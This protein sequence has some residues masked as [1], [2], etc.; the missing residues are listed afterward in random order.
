[1]PVTDWGEIL[2]QIVDAFDGHRGKI[3]GV[4]AG[5]ILSLLII[6][7]GLIRSLFI[8]FCVV[9]GY[10]IGR[11]IDDK[12]DFREIFERILPPGRS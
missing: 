8:I 4:A 10:Y 11:R 3:L 12:E 1:M 7:Y 5:F 6:N 2:R 9:S